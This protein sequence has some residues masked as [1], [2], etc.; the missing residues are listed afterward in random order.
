[1]CCRPDDVQNLLLPR[2][3]FSGTIDANAQSSASLLL[4]ELL[5]KSS[6]TC[7]IK[8]KG[9]IMGDFL[10]LQ[11]KHR[12]VEYIL[13]NR[14]FSSISVYVVLLPVYQGLTWFNRV[15]ISGVNHVFV[16]ILS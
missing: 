9:S 4:K 10:A 5:C 13:S 12:K 7:E 2:D 1:M 15:I 11:G 6:T 16:I 8:G 14:V 3:P